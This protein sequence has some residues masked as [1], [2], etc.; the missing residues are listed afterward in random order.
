VFRLNGIARTVQEVDQTARV[1][2]QHT[3]EIAQTAIG[4]ASSSSEQLSELRNAV[5]HIGEVTSVTRQNA[6]KARAASDIAG[7]SRKSAERGESVVRSAVESMTAI[8]EASGRISGISSA[9]DEVA[10]QTK[11]LSLNAAIEAARA[12]EHGYAFAVVAGEGRSLAETSAASSR[13]ITSLV[14]DST[15]QINNGSALVMKS[16]ESLNEIVTSVK[17][18]AELMEEIASATETQ[19]IAVQTVTQSLSQFDTVMQTN[20]QRSEKLSG[21]AKALDSQATHL[22]NLVSHFVLSSEGALN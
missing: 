3:K 10:F 6:K 21:T 22:E 11:L 1:L 18:L 8:L 20:L 9:M 13:E 14:V 4:L 15:E 16:G 17:Q 5:A 19:Y 2:S 12:G 7:G